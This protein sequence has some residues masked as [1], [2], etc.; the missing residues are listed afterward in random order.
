MVIRPWGMKIW[1][2]IQK[3]FNLVFEEK[4]VENVYLPSLIP[5]SFFSQEAEHVEGFAPECAVVTHHRLKKSPSS[6]T[7]EPDPT[8]K[9]ADPCVVRPTSETLFWQ[10]M[11]KW[12]SSHTQL[13]LKLNQWTNI[14]RW[15]R[16]T[17]PFLRTSEFLWQEGHTAH[18]SGEEALGFADEMVG[19]YQKGVEELLAIPTIRGIKSER[20]RFAGAEETF[21][22][23][24]MMQNGF[25]L[26]SGTS[27]YLG[28]K[29]AAAHS[30]SFTTSFG[31]KQLCHGTSWG[32]STRL[33][34]ALVMVH[35]D[36]LGLVLPPSIAPIQIRII[37][38]FKVSLFFIE[39]HF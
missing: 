30:T 1:E 10:M 6:G 19:E 21:T 12:I 20:E 29:F 15:E 17:R 39:I 11:S 26:Q 14:V 36:D 31:E 5:L 4:G 25:A 35:G 37:P 24:A 3:H 23:E 9:L 8:S 38:I 34:G 22:I 28:Q 27:H 13:P 32:I 2:G 16:R 7:L 33:L 18:A